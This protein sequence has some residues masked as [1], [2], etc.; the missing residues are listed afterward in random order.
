MRTYMSSTLLWR[1]ILALVIGLLSVIWP[2]ITIGAF[3]ILFAVYAFLA[4]GTDLVSAFRGGGAGRVAW[5]VLL[6]VL[7]FAAGLAALVWPSITVVVMVLW[8]AGW[9]LVT[10]VVE[11]VLAFGRGESGAERALFALSGLIS[12]FFGVVLIVHPGIGAVTLAV[13]FGLF[14]IMYGVT[15]LV[16]A[17]QARRAGRPDGPSG[18]HPSVGDA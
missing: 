17:A 2:G 5:Y 9:A 12:I 7:S 13:V 10:G 4:A 6:A 18:R 15:D 3:V 8:L 1:G 11:V 14:T 16:L